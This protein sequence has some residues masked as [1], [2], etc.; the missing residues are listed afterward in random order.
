MTLHLPEIRFKTNLDILERCHDLW[1]ATDYDPSHIPDPRVV[2]LIDDDYL[3]DLLRWREGVKF[4]KD[5]P[6]RPPGLR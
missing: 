6:L 1:A 2:A 3:S 4:E 5:Y